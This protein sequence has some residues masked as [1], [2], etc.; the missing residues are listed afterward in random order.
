MNINEC[1]INENIPRTLLYSFSRLIVSFIILVSI[2]LLMLE[3]PKTEIF[4]IAA[5]KASRVGYD[6]VSKTFCG[7][8]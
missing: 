6:Y 7:L 3:C 5:I 2:L 8:Q 4:R 1:F